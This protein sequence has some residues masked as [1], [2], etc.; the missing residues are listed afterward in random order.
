MHQFRKASYLGEFLV[1]E[2]S[3]S[4]D[5]KEATTSKTSTPT[6]GIIGVIYAVRKQVETREAPPKVLAVNLVSD[7]ELE[8]PVHKKS[9]LEDESI[10]FTRKDLMDTI[11]LHEDA[12][13]VTP[14][15]GGFNVKRVMIDQGSGAEIMYPELY[16]GLGFTPEDLTKYDSPLVAFNGSIFMLAG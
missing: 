10:D 7:T 14:W 4:Q 3:R 15:I 11:Q 6:Q 5:L 1:W 16:E 12:L 13:V 2:D 8:G 9:R